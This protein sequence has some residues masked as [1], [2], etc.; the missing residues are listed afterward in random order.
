M[1]INLAK[2]SATCHPGIMVLRTLAAS[3]LVPLHHYAPILHLRHSV[4][5]QVGIKF[6]LVILTCSELNVGVKG[7]FVRVLGS[8]YPIAAP[9]SVVVCLS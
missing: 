3:S 2:S 9:V 8:D 5:S 6:L 1:E 7:P 4:S